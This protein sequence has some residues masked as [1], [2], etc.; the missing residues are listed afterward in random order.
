MKWSVLMVAAL[1]RVLGVALR[2][3][4][5]VASFL[6]VGNILLW[7]S[8]AIAEI[9]TG[10]LKVTRD[11]GDDFN[12]VGA[13]VL[14]AITGADGNNENQSGG[15]I[16]VGDKAFADANPANGK[17]LSG[18]G[19]KFTWADAATQAAVR[20]TFAGDYYAWVVSTPTNVK[21][22][23]FT[24]FDP[25]TDG[26]KKRFGENN[27]NENAGALFNVTATYAVPKDT[28]TDKYSLHWIQALTG[29]QYGV[30]TPARL[31][32][33]FAK[34]TAPYYDKGG[35]AGTF[36]GKPNDGWFLDIP[37]AFENEYEQ[38]PVINRTFQVVLALEDQTTD[39]DGVKQ[40]NVTLLGGY[41]WGYTYTAVDNPEPAS[42]TLFAIGMAGAMGYAWRRRKR[43]A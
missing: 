25:K 36:A 32:N 29:S 41:E 12:T 23:G 5:V 37:N 26:F 22:G 17:G 43:T 31:D 34:G 18:Q 4:L 2:S 42:M 13:P 14:K 10:E 16:N 9:I 38:N 21:A 8:G 33:P 6:L 35:A 7:P 11:Y 39:K 30:N 1:A 19:W 20:G 3:R 27:M 24:F 40:N 15:L 28:A